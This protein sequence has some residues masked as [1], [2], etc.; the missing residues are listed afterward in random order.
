ME[1]H[2]PQMMNAGALLRDTA[3]P[4]IPTRVLDEGAL[5]TY[6]GIIALS[7]IRG[8]CVRKQLE[9]VKK[10]IILAAGGMGSHIDGKEYHPVRG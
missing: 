5:Y 2:F 3:S 7:F 9:R 4:I 8:Y 6:Y 1:L 10:K